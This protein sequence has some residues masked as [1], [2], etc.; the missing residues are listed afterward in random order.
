MEHGELRRIVHVGEF[1]TNE[2]IRNKIME[3]INSEKISEGREVLNF[4]KKWAR[5]IGTKYAISVNSGTSALIAGLEAI[6]IKNPTKKKSKIL[7]TPL[8]YVATTNAI[9]LTGFTPVFVDLDPDTFCISSELIEKT[10]EKV[11]GPESYSMIVP[12]H[13]LGYA[14][15][16]DR[17]NKIAR[18]YNLLVLEDAA[19]AHGTLYH[20]K[21]VGSLAYLSTFSFYIAHNIQAGELG[22]VNTN[23]KEISQLV[24]QIKTNGRMCNCNICTRAEGKCPYKENDQDPRFT[25]NLIGYNFKA[26]EFQAAIANVQLEEIDWIIKQR[27][28]NVKRL[29]ELLQKY[30]AIFQLPKYS[31]DVSYLVYPIVI[32][33]V[34]FQPQKIRMALEKEGIET[35]PIFG[36]IP[37]QQP[38]YSYLKNEYEGKLPVAENIGK[39]GFYIGCHQ[40]LTEVDFDMISKG[41]SKLAASLESNK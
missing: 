15:D 28:Q 41:F 24:R 32:R 33:D 40:Y 35:R 31:E 5:F 37:T 9:V 16:M 13:L 23:D 29:N 18:N 26:M 30:E 20:G 27:Q 2:K 8:T 14:A 36:C 21:K 11:D 1:R 38:A 10:L 17:I 34:K 22:A 4:E 12:V 6:K 19:Q 7:T 25:H 39:F 3:V